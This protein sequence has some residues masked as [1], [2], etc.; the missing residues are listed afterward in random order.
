MRTRKKECSQDK[1]VQWEMV[2]RYADMQNREMETPPATLANMCA[3]G[4]LMPVDVFTPAC[5][6]HKRNAKREGNRLAFANHREQLKS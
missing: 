1:Y 2:C 3:S 4:G 6:K 5:R